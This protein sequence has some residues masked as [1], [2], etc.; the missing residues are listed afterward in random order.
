MFQM[1]LPAFHSVGEMTDSSC[2]AYVDKAMLH[3]CLYALCC[4]SHLSLQC[5]SVC[6]FDMCAYS[7]LKLK[8]VV[9]FSQFETRKP[10][11]GTHVYRILGT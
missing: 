2:Y 9:V 10:K 7:L 3:S 8:Q 6:H 5:S 4:L 1:H 11:N